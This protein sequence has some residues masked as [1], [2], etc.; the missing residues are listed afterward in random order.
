M[1]NNTQ[2]ANENGEGKTAS[3][4]WCIKHCPICIIIILYIILAIIIAIG[5]IICPDKCILTS[6]PALIVWIICL[7][8]II[9]LYIIFASITE[10]KIDKISL[11]KVR[12]DNIYKLEIKKLEFKEECLNAGRKNSTKSTENGVT[13]P[14]SNGVGE[15][16]NSSGIATPS[17]SSN[18]G[19]DS[20][21]SSEDKV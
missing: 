7:T 5:Q 18:E 2:T 3:K 1:S 14:S 17:S 16:E 19:A 15:L 10:T 6:S 13:P 11:E 4:C 21:E 20:T 12:E 9:C 8:V